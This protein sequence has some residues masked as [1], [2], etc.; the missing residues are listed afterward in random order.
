MNSGNN[1]SLKNQFIDYVCATSRAV[2][3][4]IPVV[5][6]ALAELVTSV[7]PNQRIDRVAEFAKILKNNV[8]EDHE[9]LIR[10]QLENENF[11]DLLEESLMQVVRST[12]NERRMYISSIVEKGISSEKVNLIEL[13]QL[14]KILGEINDIEVI[15]LRFHMADINYGGQYTYNHDEDF[16]IRHI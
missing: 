13:K 9:K 1:E 4:P 12:T 7:I 15:W 11:T 10:L 6:S 16:R 3:G 14:L 2:L 5:G 8:S